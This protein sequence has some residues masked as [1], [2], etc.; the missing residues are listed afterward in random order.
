PELRVADITSSK[1]TAKIGPRWDV[2]VS[3]DPPA[4][5]IA[6]SVVPARTAQRVGTV[7]PLEPDT[8]S[9]RQVLAAVRARDFCGE[10]SKRRHQILRAGE[11]NSSPAGAAATAWCRAKP[12]CGPGR[13]ATPG[14]LAM[15][16]ATTRQPSN[17]RLPRT[18][19]RRSSPA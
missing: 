1:P 11:R 13:G 12:K 17:H 9:D 7:S 16:A 19:D 3:V 6:D 4:D 15:R 14:S 5:G 10:L 8:P 2:A 18:F